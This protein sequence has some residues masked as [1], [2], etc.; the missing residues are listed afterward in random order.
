MK[1]LSN[2]KVIKDLVENSY[3]GSLTSA[4]IITAIEH[5]SET[6]LQKGVPENDFVSSNLW[7]SIAAELKDKIDSYYG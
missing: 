2:K 7:I 3:Y 1:V 6:V 5:Y 4:F